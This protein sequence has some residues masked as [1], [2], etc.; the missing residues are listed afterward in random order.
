MA[1][2]GGKPRY[3]M[4]LAGYGS[5]AALAGSVGE[6]LR[7]TGVTSPKAKPL[8][9]EL[10]RINAQSPEADV[11]R[12]AA[13]F[14][15]RGSV[16]AIPTDT[17]YGLAAD[18]FNLAAVDEIYRVKGRPETR[19]LP[20]LVNSMEQAALLARDV[21]RNFVRLA[22]AFWPGGLTLVVEAS[23]RV[24][25][26]VTANTGK[27]ALRWPKSKVVERL[28]AEFEGPVTGTSAN[29]SGFPSCASADQ[30][31]KQLGAR[32]T[33][34]L[35]AGGTGAALPSTIVELRDEEWK[36]VREGAIP[37]AEIEKALD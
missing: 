29:V 33:L 17:F 2:R 6:E 34:V 1:W 19:A 21:P 30:V 14:L 24:P 9:A 27:V 15:A 25:L 3:C 22:E 12:Y 35:D 36:I 10:L 26:K 16:V 8:P 37:I 28:I 23:Q 13:D 32:L 11:L 7:G 20:I 18:P 4:D 5:V 31:M